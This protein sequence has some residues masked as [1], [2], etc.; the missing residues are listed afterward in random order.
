MTVFL[1]TI[2]TVYGG[3]HAYAFFR[4]RSAFSFGAVT[5]SALA[6][7]LL[8]M[9]AAPFLIRALELHEYERTARLL[10]F[11]A[12]LWMAALFLFFC[13][14]LSLD[15]INLV[16][17]MVHWAVRVVPGPFPLAGRTAFLISAGLALAICIYGYFEASNVRQEVLRIETAKL[18]AEIGKLT[19]VQMSDVHLGLIIRCDRLEKMLEV[20][21]AAKPDIFIVT[22]DLV[23]AQI[24]HLTGLAD[25]LREVN[26]PYGKYAITGNHEYYAGLGKALDFT[27]NAG[28]TVLRNVAVKA[29]PIMIAGVDD[30]TGV[31]LKQGKPVSELALLGGL[32]RDTFRLFLKHQPR[33]DPVTIG[34]FDLQLSGHTHKGQIFPFTYLTRLTFPLNAGRYDLGSGSVLYVSRG[35]GTWG[36]PIRFLAPPEVTVIELIR[37]PASRDGS[38]G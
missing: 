6:L 10:A 7:F 9:V 29:G 19:I 36:P 12:Y 34:L 13:I 32:P 8:L 1:L 28:F 16:A 22:G 11:I 25:L 21:K 33:I 18:P 24:N 35:T 17:R 4:A 30:R 2:I 15:L 38:A 5:G 14:S 23:D 31:Q 27:R 20:V 37:I 26:P 3:A